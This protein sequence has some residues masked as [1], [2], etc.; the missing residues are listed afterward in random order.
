MKHSIGNQYEKNGQTFRLEGVMPFEPKFMLVGD[1]GIVFEGDL[2]EYH[3]ITIS[4]R[5]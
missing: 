1:D 2:Q 3:L 5:R 4:F